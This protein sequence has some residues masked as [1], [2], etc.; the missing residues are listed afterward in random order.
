MNAT[1]Q[2]FAKLSDNSKGAALM[3]GASLAF[4]LN[5]FMMKLVFTELSV[6]QSVFLRGLFV[7]PLLILICLQRHQ[8]F[9]AVPRSD[10]GIIACRTALEITIT[11]LFL[12]ALS[13][14]SLAHV[15]AVLQAVPLI[16]TVFAA[17]I[18]REKVGWRRWMAVVTGFIGVMLIIKPGLDGFSVFSLSVLMAA[19][20]IAARD[21]LTRQLS[22]QTP[23]FFVALVTA[24]AVTVAGGIATVATGWHAPSLSSWFLMGGAALAIP[25]AYVLSIAT[26]RVGDVSFVTPFRYTAVVF[27]TILSCLLTGHLPD[28]LSFLGTILV[29]A[30]G[31]Y[32]LHREHLLA[33]Q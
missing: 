18:L 30:A 23:S 2:N 6:V 11:F 3:S 8:L 15:T 13:Q 17:I 27:A 31:I 19:I 29:I 22:V 32:C 28:R 21:I 20:L 25:A 33:T 5:D 1:L 12:L 9:A 16:L 24:L 7:C 14:L 10:R 26:M 4:V